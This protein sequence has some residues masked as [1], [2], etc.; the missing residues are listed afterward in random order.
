[1]II[2]D[3]ELQNVKSPTAV[4]GQKQELDVAFY[5]SRAFKDHPNVFI[6]NDYKFSFNNEMA[7]IDHLIVYPYGF[8]LIESKSITGEIKVNELGEWTRSSNS[9]WF[10]IPS[11]IKQAELQQTLFRKML[12]HHSSTILSKLFGL[13]EQSFGL[14]SWNILCAISSNSVIDRASI[15]KN[16]SELLVKSEF[17]VDKI[18]EVM[19][20]RNKFINS[21][22][23]LDTRLSFSDEELKSITNF[24]IEYNKPK[25]Q[26]PQSTT[27]SSSEPKSILKCKK[28]NESSNYTAQHGRYGY[29]INCNECKTN[30]SMKIECINCHSKNTKI[31]KKKDIYTLNCLDCSN[32][33]RLI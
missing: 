30:T 23:V 14:R 11:P 28:C 33:F 22:N 21:I 25:S 26:K 5:L 2:K 6:I 3:K 17:L 29:F 32:Q 24:L 31:T 9:K 8:I 7:Q 16:I 27:I 15:P 10:G 13:R 4:A 12:H 19:K 18:N 1:M 20:L